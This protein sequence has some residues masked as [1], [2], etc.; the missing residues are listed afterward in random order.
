MIYN[1][2]NKFFYLPE[3]YNQQSAISLCS[4]LPEI[5]ITELQNHFDQLDIGKILVDIDRPAK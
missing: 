5:E 4:L 3:I 2:Q 1:L